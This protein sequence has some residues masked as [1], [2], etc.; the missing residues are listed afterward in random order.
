ME[1]TL[2]TGSPSDPPN[3]ATA[4]VGDSLTAQILEKHAAGQKLTPSEHARLAVHK[5]RV[6]GRPWGRPPK[7]V[8]GGACGG[9]GATVGGAAVGAS[10]APGAPPS[11]DLDIAPCDP[12]LVRATTGAI[13]K[14][15]DGIAQRWIET[16]ARR[17]GADKDTARELGSSVA[18]D[19]GPRTLMVDTSPA[20]FESLG[21]NATNFPVY[22]FCSG[23]VAWLGGVWA[24]HERLA[25]LARLAPG[26]HS[27]AG[28]APPVP[29]A[30]PPPNQAN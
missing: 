20:V 18:L 27:A 13:L 3:P 8:G 6:A 28:A 17:I 26:P 14:T 23:L 24:A 12:A 5:A 1:T 29:T 2:A 9:T 7:T 19:D 4:V 21:I 15:L 16:E 30:V 22:A 25:R 10:P 11:D